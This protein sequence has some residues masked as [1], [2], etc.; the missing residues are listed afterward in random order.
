MHRVIVSLVFL[1]SKKMLGFKYYLN[2]LIIMLNI[3]NLDK[4]KIRQEILRGGINKLV[5]FF[6]ILV[7]VIGGAMG[8]AIL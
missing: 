7:F 8:G 3:F 1:Y 2:R 6:G 4:E 5:I